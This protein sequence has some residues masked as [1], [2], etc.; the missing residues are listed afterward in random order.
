MGSKVSSS[1]SEMT[2]CLKLDI[3]IE[4]VVKKDTIDE[5][6][7][8]SCLQNFF[9]DTTGPLVAVFEELNKEEPDT[10]L[11]CAAVQQA[12]LFWGNAS[13]HLSHVHR[14][15]ILKRLNQDDQGLAKDTDFSKRL[16]TSSEKGLSKR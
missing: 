15:K 13:T 3:I 16:P 2:R 14:M 1:E 8:L 5:D 10:D 9:L 12:L 7:E 4:E 6:R 11:T